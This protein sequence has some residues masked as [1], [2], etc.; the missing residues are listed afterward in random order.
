[1]FEVCIDGADTCN[2]FDI[3]F[4]FAYP[5]LLRANE[6]FTP[7][8][9]FG[10]RQLIPTWVLFAVKTSEKIFFTLLRVRSLLIIFTPDIPIEPFTSSVCCGLLVC[11][12]KLLDEEYN[13]DS[14]ELLD[15]A[16]DGAENV[17]EHDSML[18]LL[19]KDS[20]DLPT[21]LLKLIFDSTDRVSVGIATRIP[22]LFEY[23]IP[24]LDPFHWRIC[25]T[26]W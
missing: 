15:T 5:W 8:V 13:Q 11:T 26:P 1:M 9:A 10:V 4:R 18:A 12:P 20:T 21:A 22:T 7:R 2:T 19:P 14:P 25:G 23:V 16:K 3:M 6:P 24:M 17:V